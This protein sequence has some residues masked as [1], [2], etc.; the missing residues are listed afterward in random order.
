MKGTPTCLKCKAT[1]SPMWTNAENL[2]A[3]CLNCVNETKDIMKKEQEEDEDD[4]QEET[5]T[6]KRK[7]RQT[8][9]YKTR[10]NPLAL[11]KT[12]QPKGGKGRRQIFKQRPP[13]KAPMA[14]ATPVTS[15]YVF[16]KV[17][18]VFLVKSACLYCNNFFR[19]VIFK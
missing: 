3:L 15:N 5:K 14:V 16:H 11:P 17:N 2:G 19:E 12:A 9:S 1:E 10:L 6:G 4:K 18:F 13:L 8:R 7:I